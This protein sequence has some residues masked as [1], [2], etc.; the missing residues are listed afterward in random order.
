MTPLLPHSRLRSPWG[1][2]MRRFWMVRLLVGL[3]VIGLTVSAARADA[4]VAHLSAQLTGFQQ[5]PPILTAGTGSFNATVRDASLTYRLTYTRLS[6]PVT[7][8]H[9]HFAQRDVN[10]G[11]FVWLCGSATSPG[12]TGTPIC[13]PNGGTVSRTITA[14]DIVAP[15]PDQ[16]LAA[17]DFAGALRI[18]RVG[19]A[20]VNVHTTRFPAGEI[21]GQIQ[22][23]DEN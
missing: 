11:I 1:R 8:A 6:T 9:I 17:G 7:Q 20:Y 12:P 19:E 2:I 23:R 22:V 5:V 16:G 15:T 4:G 3:A 21:R 14:A 10:G 13:P 18:I